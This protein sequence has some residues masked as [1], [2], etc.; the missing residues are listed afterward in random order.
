MIEIKNS[1]GVTIKMIEKL[2]ESLKEEK[3]NR[4][5]AQRDF[6]NRIR[7]LQREAYKQATRLGAII[8]SIVILAGL[9]AQVLLPKIFGL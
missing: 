6:D 7:D 5:E 1:E 3:G 8:G 2:L 4:L 9:I